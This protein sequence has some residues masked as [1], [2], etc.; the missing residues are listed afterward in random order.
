VDL[1]TKTVLDQFADALMQAT[2]CSHLVDL[3]LELGIAGPL[4]SRMCLLRCNPSGVL[5]LPI[6]LSEFVEMVPVPFGATSPINFE[7]VG[8]H[9][10][11]LRSDGSGKAAGVAKMMLGK[12]GVICFDR[13]EDEG[14]ALDIAE[15]IETTLSVQQHIAKMP[16]WA[17][18]SAGGIESLPHRPGVQ[19]LR[20]FPDN[21]ES[22]RGWIA[23]RACAERW[24]EAGTE[25]KAT[26]PKHHKDWNDHVMQEK[27]W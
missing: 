7:P 18:G 24:S 21:D 4:L 9:R 14:S 15:G 1:M 12:A 11:F 25:V 19:L 10:T 5:C 17:C 13:P 16:M 23:A 8:I 6:D 26:S 22:G 2:L 20:I 27:R 3:E